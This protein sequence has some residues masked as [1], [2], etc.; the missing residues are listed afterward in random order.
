MVVHMVVVGR[1]P[2]RVVGFGLQLVVELAL[3]QL[4]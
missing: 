2:R 3:V 4:A 1:I